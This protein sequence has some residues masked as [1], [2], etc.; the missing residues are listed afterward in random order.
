VDRSSVEV[1]AADGTA[2]TARVY[3]RYA[4]SDA[5]RAVAEGGA[6]PVTRLAAWRM[7]SAWSA[8]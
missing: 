5:V 6:A 2:L 3:P 4:E 1:F 8:S 7:G